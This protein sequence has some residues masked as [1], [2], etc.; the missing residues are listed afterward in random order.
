MKQKISWKDYSLNLDLFKIG[1]SYSRTQ[2]RKIGLLPE[3]PGPQEN[4][5]GIVVLKNTILIFVTLDKANANKDHLYNDYF[6]DNDFFWESQNRN[7]INTSPVNRIISDDSNY[8]FIRVVDKIKSKTSEFTFA[9]RISPVDFNH[10]TRP[11]Q[12]QFEALDYQ[13]QPNERLEKIYSWRPGINFAPTVVADPE[14]PKKRKTSQGFQRDQAKKDA[15]EARAMEV[16]KDYYENQGFRVKDCSMQRGLGYDYLCIKAK[17]VIEVEVK[18]L[19]GNL[20]KV[21][22]TR[23]ELNNALNSINRTDLFIVYSIN[24]ET[25]QRQVKGVNGITHVLKG[26]KPQKKD[27]EPITFNYLI[28]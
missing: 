4:W 13:T 23:N 20:V 18:G 12:F 1:E 15:T 22:I 28:R 26:W 17:E 24:F 25:S 10:E 14:R 2:I 11:I 16:A 8:L 21:I 5:G 6:D 19:T 7:T 27:L 3:N 9:G